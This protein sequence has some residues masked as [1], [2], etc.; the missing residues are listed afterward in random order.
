MISLQLNSS[1]HPCYDVNS[2]QRID[3]DQQYGPIYAN[4]YELG[5]VTYKT[6]STAGL[7]PFYEFRPI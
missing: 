5:E 3:R 1:Y 7:N 2:A 6:F 4:I